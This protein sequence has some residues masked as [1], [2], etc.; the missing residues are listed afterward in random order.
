MKKISPYTAAAVLVVTRL[1]AYALYIPADNEYPTVTAISC[2]IMTLIKCAALLPAILLSKQMFFGGP[3]NLSAGQ[4]KASRRIYCGT[5]ALVLGISS[6]IALAAAGSGFRKLIGAVY[7]DRFSTVGISVIWFAACAYVASMGLKGTSRVSAFL[8]IAFS[9]IILFTFIGMR[10]LMLT[11]RVPI[12]RSTLFS[13]LGV[14]QW[15]LAAELF[16]IPI[17]YG[18]LPHIEIRTHLS[19]PKTA[20]IYL[21]SDAAMSMTTFLIYASMLGGFKSASGYSLFTLFSCTQGTFI[22]RTDGILTSIA[23]SSGIVVCAILL[24]IVTDC[25]RFFLPKSKPVKVISIAALIQGLILVSNG[26]RYDKGI[27][28]IFTATAAVC[29]VLFAL[30]S[31]IGAVI[32]KREEKA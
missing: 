28:N 21:I 27:N 6:M 2:L 5:A 20:A 12:S 7:P 24:L 14:S 15:R 31:V 23:C 16:D 8:A 13:Q 25:V 3:D 30:W 29:A 1:F 9:A 32:G 19:V 10:E 4:L 22:D 18:L 17:F 26:S 11:D